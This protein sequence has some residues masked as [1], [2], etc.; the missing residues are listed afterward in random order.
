MSYILPNDSVST[1][2]QL[3]AE[4]EESKDS[5]GILGFGA[6][7]TTMEEVFMKYVL[8]LECSKY[9]N[10]CSKYSDIVLNIV[11]RVLN[12]VTRVLNIVTCVLNIATRVLNIVTRVLYI[13]TCVLNKYDNTFCFPGFSW[14][15]ITHVHAVC[16]IINT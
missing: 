2:P 12:I 11:T 4:L 14:Y 6:S 8:G 7:V 1:F 16:Y 9:S 15:N 10:T 3:F 13:V 5:M